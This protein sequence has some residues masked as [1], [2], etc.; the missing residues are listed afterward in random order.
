MFMYKYELDNCDGERDATRPHRIPSQRHGVT[1]A[2]VTHRQ[3]S[4]RCVA[5]AACLV[6][7]CRRKPLHARHPRSRRIYRHRPRL[8]A[9]GR[10]QERAERFSHSL[11]ASLSPRK[12]GSSR[13]YRQPQRNG[14][15]PDAAALRSIGRCY[16]AQAIADAPLAPMP[17]TGYSTGYTYAPAPGQLAPCHRAAT[18]RQPG[19]HPT[20]PRPQLDGGAVGKPSARHFCQPS[21]SASGSSRANNFPASPGKRVAA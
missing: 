16:P 2:D 17:P 6:A 14:R 13:V 5:D 19:G 15:K 21:N 20:P 11:G 10:R 9:V 8:A 18:S 3:P 7:D 1:A 12:G 4:G